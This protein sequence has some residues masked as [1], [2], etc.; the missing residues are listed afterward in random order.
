VS[1]PNPFEHRT[2]RIRSPL[3]EFVRDK[4]MDESPREVVRILIVEDDYLVASDIESV[5]VEAGLEVAGIAA[6]AEEAMVLAASH[7]PTLA[8]MDVR[9]GGVRDG[10][11]VAL[12]LFARQGIRC[13]FATAHYDGEVRARAA[14]A[15]PLGWLQKPFSRTSLI[16]SVRQALRDLAGVQ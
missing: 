1:P 16:A 12:E 3:L 8:V 10:I 5:L 11:D 13:V 2:L 15:C 9:L 4:V 6:T 7:R 14:P